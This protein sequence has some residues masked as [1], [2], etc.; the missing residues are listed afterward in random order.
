[1]AEVVP[2]VSVVI[3]VRD[4]ED[5]LRRCLDH[6]ERQEYPSDR[7]EVV[8]ADNGSRRPPVEALTSAP[9]ARLVQEPRAGSYFARNAALAVTR[10]DVVAFTDA[11]CLPGPQWLAAGVAALRRDPRAGLVAGSVDVFPS[12]AARPRAVEL[13][14]MVHGFPQARYAR[15]QHFGAT[16]NV[17]T[18]RAVIDEVGAFD[19]RLSSG[20]DKEWGRRVHDAG[21][22]VRY[23]PAVRVGHPARPTWAEHRKKLDRVFAGELSARTNRGEGPGQV[24][25]LSWRSLVPPVGSVLR[26]LGDDRLAGPRDRLLYAGGATVARWQ[27]TRA[28]WRAR[29]RALRGPERSPGSSSRSLPGSW[30]GLVVVCAGSFFGGHRLADRHVAERLTDLGVPVLYVDPPVSAVGA[31]RDAVRREAAA[32]PALRLVRPGLARFTPVAPPGK[33]RG[34]MA[35]VTDVM[36]RRQL[37]RVVSGLTGDV[38]AVLAVGGRDV[39]GACGERHSVFWARDDFTAGAELMNVPVDRVRAQELRAAAAADLVLAVSPALEERWRG[40]GYRTAMV[41]NGCDSAALASVATAEPAED[42]T[43]PG[44]VL[45]VVGTI[46][47]R[48]DLGLLEALADRGH[49]LLLV[50]QRQKNLADARFARLLDRPNVQWVGHRGW[51]RLPSYFRVIDVGLVPYGDS[52]F[53]RA[54]FPLKTLEYLAAGLPVVSTPLPATTWLASDLVR[55]AG[56]ADAFVEAVETALEEG[57][58]PRTVSARLEFAAGHDWSSRAR[59]ILALLP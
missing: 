21:W 27:G 6:L 18:R 49:S 47:S 33:S 41:P 13:F 14:Q 50:G 1:M 35:R 56:T 24:G 32:G 59:S 20:G 38:R 51:D 43:V 40:A 52:P 29:R 48:I 26:N 15:E 53:N 25:A 23:D 46:G 8:V 9:H 16:A 2:F 19:T 37:S 28:G 12:D 4:D 39:L 10:G 7:F 30:D 22:T 5:G 11:D 57:D 36:L 17:F 44:P 58:D 34:A 55:V 54:S 31:R 3:P 45:G 42:V